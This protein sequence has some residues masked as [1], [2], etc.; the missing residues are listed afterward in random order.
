MNPRRYPRCKSYK[1]ENN[2]QKE[3]KTK[4]EFVEIPF[5]EVDLRTERAIK[6]FY[7]A[8]RRKIDLS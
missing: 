3:W 5:L 1:I 4:V 8:L 6:I 2:K 7:E